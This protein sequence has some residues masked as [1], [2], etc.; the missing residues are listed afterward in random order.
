VNAALAR[1]M[2]VLEQAFKASGAELPPLFITSSS[3]PVF[4][5]ALTGRGEIRWSCDDPGH[6]DL[7]TELVSLLLKWAPTLLDEV[8]ERRI[9]M[10]PA[11][12]VT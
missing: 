10:N 7:P 1:R 5:S 4:I 11:E 6:P 8:R 9:S 12:L 2:A 3:G